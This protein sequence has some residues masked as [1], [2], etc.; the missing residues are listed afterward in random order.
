MSK[1]DSAKSI[2]EYCQSCHLHRN[3]DGEK[4][5]AEARL[6]FNKDP[7]KTATD[8]QTCHSYSTDFW[9]DGFRATYYPD[10]KLTGEPQIGKK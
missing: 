5:V 9:G 3:F 7:F 6:K 2:T 10:G 8:C 4:H 1:A